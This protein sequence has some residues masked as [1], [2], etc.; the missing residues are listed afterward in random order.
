MSIRATVLAALAVLQLAPARA[1]YYNV[2][3][4]TISEP[5]SR[6]PPAGAKVAVGYLTVTNTGREPDRLVG[7]TIAIA[8]KLELHETTLV[9]GVMQMRELTTGLVLE[10]GQTVQFRPGSHHMMFA[11][12][13]QR[14]K[15]GDRIR[16]TLVFEKAGTAEIEYHVEPLG[17]T[18]RDVR[19][20]TNK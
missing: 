16:G 15:L 1:E 10:P 20:P 9:D 19:H 2:G 5:W 13:R 6:V 11:G 17:A 4:I 3:T 7:G 14:P 12:L 18:R 8:E